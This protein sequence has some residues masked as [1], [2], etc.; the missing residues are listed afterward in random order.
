MAL[1]EIE[2]SADVQ[3]TS[4]ARPLAA[5]LPDLARSVSSA[6]LAPF[7]QPFEPLLQK[8]MALVLHSHARARRLAEG[9]RDETRGK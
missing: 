7:D 9:S 8:E 3:S 6:V 5:E 2:A 4:F 1:E